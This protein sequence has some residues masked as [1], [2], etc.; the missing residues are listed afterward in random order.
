MPSDNQVPNS[1]FSLAQIHRLLRPLRSKVKALNHAIKSKSKHRTKSSRT[2]SSDGIALPTDFGPLSVIPHPSRLQSKMTG[3]NARWDPQAQMHGMSVILLAQKIYAIVDAFRNIVERCYGN[4]IQRTGAVPSLME[5]CLGII[6][7]DIEASVH[8]L[9]AD[10]DDSHEESDDDEEFDQESDDDDETSVIDGCY[11]QIPEHLRRWA[12]VPHAIQII[13][14]HVPIFIPTLLELCL[15]VAL[16]SASQRDTLTILRHL[17]HHATTR[18]GSFVPITSPQ[19]TNYLVSLL[20]KPNAPSK[21]LTQSWAEHMF[22]DEV[23]T[24]VQQLDSKSRLDFWRSRAVHGLFLVLSDIGAQLHL[25]SNLAGLP[26]LTGPTRAR[27]CSWAEAILST[28]TQ[29]IGNHAAQPSVISNVFNIDHLGSLV[30]ELSQHVKRRVSDDEDSDDEDEDDAGQITS[31]VTSLSTIALTLAHQ[32]NHTVDLQ[33][34]RESE[35]K[36]REIM[37]TISPSATPAYF[38]ALIRAVF[39]SPQTLSQDQVQLEQED[40]TS[41]ISDPLIERILTYADALHKTGLSTL[42]FA[43]LTAVQRDHH[44]RMT[45]DDMTPSTFTSEGVLEKDAGE[46]LRWRL[47]AVRARCGGR[48]D[49]IWDRKEQGWV[50]SVQ[51]NAVNVRAESIPRSK[52][53]GLGKRCH[54]AG[55]VL[56]E[57][58]ESFSRPTSR[59][60]VAA[61]DSSVLRVEGSSCL[62]TPPQLQRSTFTISGA[63][64]QPSSPDLARK[65]CP[66]SPDILSLDSPRQRSSIGRTRMAE[67]HWEL[68]S[69]LPLPPEGENAQQIHLKPKVDLEFADIL[70]DHGGKSSQE[71]GTNSGLCKYLPIPGVDLRVDPARR[72]SPIP[73]RSHARLGPDVP[74][75]SGPTEPAKA[76]SGLHS[77]ATHIQEA[78]SLL[79]IEP[80]AVRPVYGRKARLERALSRVSSS[81]QLEKLL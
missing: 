41:T 27:L 10:K 73:V 40:N 50:T 76:G 31:L 35:W 55:N 48:E 36:I 52:A 26:R 17:L 51:P 65:H 46:L 4:A 77:S 72:P 79:R 18:Q 75:S 3:S 42:E 58:Q 28:Y 43:L 30:S 1:H 15:D 63:V 29:G 57:V 74:S 70:D 5:V 62:Y 64:S 54:D 56:N 45:F 39:F 20:R 16:E 59:R 25:V 66:S 81:S 67:A 11:E 80:V 47:T 21:P 32:S 7:G 68:L 14:I 78:R 24:C 69:P 13:F 61:S 22:V 23:T 19:H 44:A 37:H 34:N 53:G 8:E 9:L 60:R 38:D 12:L 33:L 71:G 2:S 6:G 49:W